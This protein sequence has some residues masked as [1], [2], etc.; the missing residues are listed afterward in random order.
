MDVACRL[1][2]R[3]CCSAL[4]GG[5]REWRMTDE[6]AGYARPER[7]ESPAP[8][9]DVVR[10]PLGVWTRAWNISGLRKAALLI[11]LMAAW[12]GYARWLDNPLLFPTFSSTL[13]ALVAGI[14][15]GQIPR[16]AAFTLSLLLRGYLLGLLLA[17][18]L[19]TCAVASRL[20]SD[21]LE[22]LSAMF[23]PLPSVAL[24]PLALIWFGL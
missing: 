12:E 15:S 22:T 3:N 7:V 9:Q 2:S 6:R 19:T 11:V 8:A 20:G 21:L 18:V 10:Q 5:T 23:N 16:A 17:G 24:L 14:G 13:A 1:A 4:R